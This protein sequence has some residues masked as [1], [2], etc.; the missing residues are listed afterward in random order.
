[1]ADAPLPALQIQY[2]NERPVDLLDLTGSLSALGERYQEFAAERGAGEGARLYVR[3]MR[4]G[5]IIAELQPL[6][7][8]MSFVLEHRE[9]IAA[10]TANLN[11]LF[12]FF[13]ALPPRP[14]D[15]DVSR[16][17]AEQVQ[18][19]LEP[20]AKDGGAQLFLNIN[21]DHA[22]PVIN[23]NAERAG[24]IQSG[25]RRFLDAVPLPANEFFEGEVLYLKQVKD[26][27]QAK[28][29]DRGVI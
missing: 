19:I 15:S 13:L 3:E 27:P 25:A 12:R 1:M 6:L 5:S 14:W 4:V 24:A 20:T 28:T 21:G 10:F 17:D 26:D 22:A 8:Q 23:I 2:D 29:G 9:T 11:D 18:K 16:R 7:E